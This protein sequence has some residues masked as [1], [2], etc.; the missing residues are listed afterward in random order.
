MCV[1]LGVGGGGGFHPGSDTHTPYMIVF[2]VPEPVFSVS[3][4]FQ[5]CF[6]F[7][8][9][10]WAKNQE[11]YSLNMHNY[12]V[13]QLLCLLRAAAH[14]H[15]TRE[16]RTIDI[17]IQPKKKTNFESWMKCKVQEGRLARGY[18]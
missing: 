10:E 15:T 13:S 16:R 6:F 8:K 7:Y 12:L 1:C 17:F 2:R 11:W 4:G 9:R 14:I 3:Q 5:G 18:R